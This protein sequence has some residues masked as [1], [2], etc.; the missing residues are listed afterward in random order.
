MRKRNAP[1]CSISYTTSTAQHSYPIITNI[2]KPQMHASG[3]AAPCGPGTVME[4]QSPFGAVELIYKTFFV[5]DR[6][7]KVPGDPWIS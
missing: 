2:R 6:G 5:G 3:P 7:R 1:A 4:F